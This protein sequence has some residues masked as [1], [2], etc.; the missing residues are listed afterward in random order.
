VEAEN[1]GWSGYAPKGEVV[2]T[3][4]LGALIQRREEGEKRKE[5]E[6]GC[7]PAVS[8]SPGVRRGSASDFERKGEDLRVG[9]VCG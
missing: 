5:E 7:W 1:E 6:G 4:L 2:S 8:S 9:K 3:E